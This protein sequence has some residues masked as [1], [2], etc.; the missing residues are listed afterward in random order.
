ML[1]Q[2]NAAG[3]MFTHP[4]GPLRWSLGHS[5]HVL[6]GNA[7]THP[8]AC[9][10]ERETHT[11]RDQERPQSDATVTRRDVDLAP[12]QIGQHCYRITTLRTPKAKSERAKQRESTSRSAGQALA[13]APLVSRPRCEMSDPTHAQQH[14]SGRE[15]LQPTRIWSITPNLPACLPGHQPRKSIANQSTPTCVPAWPPETSFNATHSLCT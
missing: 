2:G 11:S 1:V 13:T 3:C 6:T 9:R 12:L 14:S 10:V 15:G 8:L 5:L 7:P 4:P